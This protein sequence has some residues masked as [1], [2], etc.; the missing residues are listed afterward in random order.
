MEVSEP[1]KN[2]V[3]YLNDIGVRLSAFKLENASDHTFMYKWS[4]FYLLFQ[5]SKEFGFVVSSAGDWS[6]DLCTYPMSIMVSLF[7]FLSTFYWST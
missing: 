2:I 6:L 3:V 4:G 1:L 5:M 7:R